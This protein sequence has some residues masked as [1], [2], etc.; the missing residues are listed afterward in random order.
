M[1]GVCPGSEFPGT[2][3]DGVVA[4]FRITVYV[5]PGFVI[6]TA[7]PTAAPKV[8]ATVRVVGSTVEERVLNA[9]GL[10]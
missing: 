2:R 9:N 3:E 4:G 6:R 10:H 1:T 7:G 8:S 5:D